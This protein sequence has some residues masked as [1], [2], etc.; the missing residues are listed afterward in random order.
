MTKPRHLLTALLGSLLLLASCSTETDVG[1]ITLDDAAATAIDQAEDATG[2]TLGPER[3]EA[4]AK[5]QTSMDVVTAQLETGDFGQDLIV[6]WA[7][8]QTRVSDAVVSVQ[9]DPD[10]NAAALESILDAF[11]A[12]LAA[13]GSQPELE[14]AWTEFRAAFDEF[15]AGSTT[16][17]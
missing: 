10:F 9:A 3:S 16:S 17:G 12:Q 5:L 6:T 4:I 1:G 15:I 13:F 8:I 14:G 11:G 7:E 2:T